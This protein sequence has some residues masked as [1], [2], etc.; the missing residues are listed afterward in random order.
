MTDYD[1][2]NPGTALNLWRWSKIPKEKRAD[3]V[4]RNG[5]RPCTYPPCTVKK[6]HVWV[7]HVCRYCGYKRDPSEAE[8]RVGLTNIKTSGKQGKLLMKVRE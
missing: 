8:K 2:T 7:E 5:G 6:R 4:P 3:Y 1:G